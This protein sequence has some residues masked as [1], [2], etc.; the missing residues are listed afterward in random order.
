MDTDATVIEPAAEAEGTRTSARTSG[1]R[2]SIEL[3]TRAEPR[4]R[5]SVE[6]KQSI[7]AENLATDAS[8]MEVACRYGISSGLLYAWGKALLAAQSSI[9][10]FARVAVTAAQSQLTRHRT[11]PSC[12]HLRQQW[13]RSRSFCRTARPSGGTHRSIRALCAGCCRCWPGHDRPATG[14]ASLARPAGSFAIGRVSAK[15]R[16][17]RTRCPGTANSAAQSAADR[18]LLPAAYVAIMPYCSMPDDLGIRTN[19]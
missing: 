13:T 2:P 5:W 1:R 14:R 9:A 19:L 16:S 10:R 7:A 3:I 17:N 4:Q 11:L 12:R 18:L 8:P 15:A 6:Q